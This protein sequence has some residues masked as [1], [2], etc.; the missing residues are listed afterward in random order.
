MVTTIQVNERTLILLKKLKE[1]MRADSYEEVI[2]KIVAERTNNIS[3]A[4]FLGEKYGK[5]SKKEILKNLRD[6]NDRI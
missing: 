5:I 4:G 1:Q 2:N 6:K 3:F